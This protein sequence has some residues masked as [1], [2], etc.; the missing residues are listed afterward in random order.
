MTAYSAESLACGAQLSLI[1]SVDDRRAPADPFRLSKAIRAQVD[2][3]AAALEA[4]D[5]L[6][7]EA[8]SA[9]SGKSAAARIILDALEQGLRDAHAEITAKRASVISEPERLEVFS[10]YGW[11]GGYLGRFDDSRVI[12][13]ARLGVR[14]QEN[15]AP[16]FRYSEDLVRELKE[17]LESLD[18]VL[19]EATSGKR[20]VA[21]QRRKGAMKA[22]GETLAQVRSWYCAASRQGSKTKELAT[23]GMQP[24]RGRRSAD[25]VAA[26]QKLIQARREE[27]IA[28]R[29]Q[30][31]AKKQAEQLLKA[32]ERHQ[33]LQAEI[34]A[35]AETLN[36]LSGGNPLVHG[37]VDGDQVELSS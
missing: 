23:I 31:Q 33:R 29:E 4:V 18:D 19:P 34:Q 5:T 1:Q 32:Q 36:R 25:V 21:V 15:L 37:E 3:D 11:T 7:L 26:E 9:R 6:A 24:R 2:A 10:A 22:A 28:R 30:E 20:Q 13:L 14:P 8:E 12:G 27:R 17:K 16:E 35:S